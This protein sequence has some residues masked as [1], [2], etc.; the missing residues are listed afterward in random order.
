M[1]VKLVKLVG[2]YHTA[3]GKKLKGSTLG[4]SPEVSLGSGRSGFERWGR[5][6]IRALGNEADLV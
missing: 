3:E 5:F 6:E 2:V 4:G 1:L